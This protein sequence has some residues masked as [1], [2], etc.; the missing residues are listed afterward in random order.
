MSF[1]TY[2]KRSLLAPAIYRSGIPFKSWNSGKKNVI[3]NYHGVIGG[4][5]Q[6][7]NNRH[8]PS[9]QFEADLK[10]FRKHFNVVSLAELFA[11]PEPIDSEF[12]P[13]VAITFDDGFENNCEFAL[14]I[15]RKYNMPATIFVLTASIEDPSFVN[16][17]DLLDVMAQVNQNK[18]LDFMDCRFIRNDSVF[19]SENDPKVSLS[20]FIK[21]Q[22]V[23]RI[24]PLKRLAKDLVNDKKVMSTFGKHLKL[25]SVKQLHECSKSGLIE[26]ASHSK[27]HFNLG[28]VDQGLVRTELESSR[29]DLEEVLQNEVLSIAYPDGDYT[30]D[31]KAIAENVGYTRQLAV[32]FM[33]SSDEQDSRIR[34]R[35]SYS[36][37]TNHA[38]NMI[39][40]GFQWNK[41]SF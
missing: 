21:N 29:I 28:R 11:N 8:M 13:K 12:L 40:L 38:S 9:E 7:I 5:F 10:F 1:V 33:N 30:D 36:N 23:D 20:E 17:A 37:S 4:A 16:W 41:F 32:G 18:I 24:E 19:I 2:I 39:R 26:I 15:L 31:V 27:N 35:F 34:R 25:M 3:F 6:R 14:P 22:G